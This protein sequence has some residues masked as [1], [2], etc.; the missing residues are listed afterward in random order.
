MKDSLILQ[1]VTRANK[2]NLSSGSQPSDDKRLDNLYKHDFD[3][4]NRFLEEFDKAELSNQPAQVELSRDEQPLTQSTKTDLSAEYIQPDNLIF[5]NTSLQTQDPI[6]AAKINKNKSLPIEGILQTIKSNDP[7]INADIINDIGKDNTTVKI[8]EDIED[9]L[10]TIKLGASTSDIEND[11]SDIQSLPTNENIITNSIARIDGLERVQLGLATPN[12]SQNETR[13]VKHDSLMH[14]ETAT[15]NPST[16]INNAE[17]T[18]P[19]NPQGEFISNEAN[20]S[21]GPETS[22]TDNVDLDSIEIDTIDIDENDIFLKRETLQ[23]LGTAGAPTNLLGGSPLETTLPNT[24]NPSFSLGTAQTQ[25]SGTTTLTMPPSAPI[26]TPAHSNAVINTVSQAMLIAKETSQGVMV[27]IDPPEMGRV[28]I[29]FMFE[30]DSQVNVVVK[31]DTVASHDIL[32]ERAEHFTQMLKDNG[33]ENINLSFEQQGSDSNNT[34]SQSD[35]TE[36][37]TDKYIA[38]EI[39]EAQ[40]QAYNPALYTANQDNLRLDIKL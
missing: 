26:A 24:L 1:P 10:S 36:F 2:T 21:T 35:D 37:G 15:T 20:I 6:G 13:I 30:S 31:S 12:I 29:D 8:T 5:V 39:I 17:T 11:F 14:F 34:N 9:V 7:I 40:D 33:F 16:T 18:L 3:D 23:A 32:R 27:Q 22:E 4:K 25:V 38:A 28:Y 19:Q